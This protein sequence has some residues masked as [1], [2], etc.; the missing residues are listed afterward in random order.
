MSNQ[1][2]VEKIEKIEIKDFEKVLNELVSDKSLEK[3]RIQYEKLYLA[4][5]KS[6]ENEEKLMRKCKELSNELINDRNKISKVI[7]LASKDEN[8]VILLKNEIN[9][10]WKM[11][12]ITKEKEKKGKKTIEILRS[13]ISSLKKLIES[14]VGLNNGQDITMNELLKSKQDLTNE[15]EIKNKKLDKQQIEIESLNNELIKYK[16]NCNK[17]EN[18]I[19]ELNKKLSKYK[20]DFSRN[21]RTME[22]SEKQLIEMKKYFDDNNN[23]INEY[24]EIIKNKDDEINKIKKIIN[25]KD[26][27]IS[28]INLEFD[29]L[30]LQLSQLLEQCELQRDEQLNLNKDKQNLEKNIKQK[31]NEISGLKQEI[32]SI[33]KVN[34]LNFKKYND[35]QT[36]YNILQIEKNK[37]IEI[38]NEIKKDI[39]LEEKLKKEDKRI[40][41]DLNLD[42]K[43][44]SNSFEI[45][46]KKNETLLSE[47]KTLK[48]KIKKLSTDLKLSND[49]ISELIKGNINLE[50][51]NDKLSISIDN[52]NIKKNELKKNINILKIES[53]DM[54]NILNVE[55]NKLKKQ[56]YLYENIRN[57]R[58]LFCQ[59][60]NFASDE[61]SEMKRKFK[62]M[63]HQ[64]E[65][66]KE[67][68]LSKDKGLIKQHFKIKQLDE[69]IKSLE[70]QKIK[71]DEI[72]LNCDKL[73]N[74]QN[75]EIKILRKTLFDNQ[76][77]QKT[78]KKIFDAI[79]NE[80]D[81]LSIQ[82]IRR[83]DELSLLYDKIKLMQLT[84]EK[85]QYQY[86]Q[87]LNDIKNLSLKLQTNKNKLNIRN[88]QY[89]NINK[90]KYEINNLQRELLSEKT[91][92][93]ALSEELENPINVHRW[94]K[95]IGSDPTKFES[96][97][98]IQ[99]L[100]KRL[101]NKTEQNVEKDLI[102]KEK[103]KLYIQLKNILSRQPGP[104]IIEKLNIYQQTIK[105]KTK[106]IK[107][108]NA[109]LN[110]LQIQLNQYKFDCNNLNQQL[111]IMKK[112]YYQQKKK[113]Q[114]WKEQT[115]TNNDDKVKS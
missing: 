107:S 5:K 15:I 17:F 37:F 25:I 30:K 66:Y 45:N 72:L 97:Q 51:K 110:M 49:K 6:N 63:I 76:I 41:S 83:N 43:K 31:L 67:E 60:L 71:K 14:G 4:L 11:V 85:G 22:K 19:N 75:N 114:L 111:I 26:N 57:E 80:R 10:A 20:Q 44:L 78:Q 9:K 69:I 40:I 38:L 98:K 74:S 105:D 32:I 39:I 84:L 95:L 18:K 56:Q 1:S 55:K 53:K 70:K 81:I 47:I 23:K 68:T 62:I 82:I 52:N 59:N 113:E 61:I 112:K 3:F 87:R 29:S 89:Q 50:K 86:K 58:N 77:L 99:T 101:I 96:I 94:R 115:R 103:E 64:I 100:Q 12:D 16:L 21:L 27:K 93:K 91:K 2:K 88:I 106:Q 34:N 36:K 35:L 7:D 42:L 46:K 108:N 92:V 102:I 48:S 65:Q 24:K 90:L 73:L 33:Q 54:L 28:T 109:E 8:N 79:I 13:E 104:E